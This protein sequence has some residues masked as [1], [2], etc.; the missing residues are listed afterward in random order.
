MEQAAAVIWGIGSFVTFLLMFGQIHISLS[1]ILFVALVVGRP[2]HGPAQEYRL[3]RRMNATRA[4]RIGAVGLVLR[5][6]AILPAWSL[7]IAPFSYV[8]TGLWGG[9]PVTL[10]LATYGL[11]VRLPAR[12]PA[13]ARPALQPAADQG[14]VRGLSSS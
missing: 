10:I 8:E 4:R 11:V 7:A 3:G 2:R 14:P 12:H 13:G 1:L 5:M 6:L 9:M